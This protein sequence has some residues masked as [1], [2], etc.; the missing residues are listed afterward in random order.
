MVKKEKNKKNK[1]IEKNFKGIVE[2]DKPVVFDFD[3]PENTV[4]T[5]ISFKT[6]IKKKKIGC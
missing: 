5:K 2:P 4:K 3:I 6:D 1:I